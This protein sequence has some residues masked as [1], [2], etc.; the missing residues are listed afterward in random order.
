MAIENQFADIM[1]KAL[2]RARFLEPRQKI[3]S[4]EVKKAQ[5]D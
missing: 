4:V 5:K 1:T 2:G 3:G